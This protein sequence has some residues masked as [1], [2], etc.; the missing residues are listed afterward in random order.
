[1]NGWAGKGL[2]IEWMDGWME[3]GEG[4]DGVVRYSDTVWSSRVEEMRVNDCGLG[5]SASS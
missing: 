1:M 5:I 4:G 2:E 3:R